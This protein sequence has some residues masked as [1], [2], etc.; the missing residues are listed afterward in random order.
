METCSLIYHSK[1]EFQA[2]VV[3]T[4]DWLLE[5]RVICLD[6]KGSLVSESNTVFV[7]PILK[8][9]RNMIEGQMHVIQNEIH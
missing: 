1:L 6:C 9:V 7:M 5:Y 8:L 2:S 3:L 4:L